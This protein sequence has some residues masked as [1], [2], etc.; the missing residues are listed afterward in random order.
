MEPLLC[1]KL[2]AGHWQSQ[3]K[4]GFLGHLDAGRVERFM[5]SFSGLCGAILTVSSEGMKPSVL[6]YTCV[7]IHVIGGREVTVS[8]KKALRTYFEHSTGEQIFLGAG[9]T[10]ARG[11]VAKLF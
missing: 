9:F 6:T 4:G 5:R 10:V 8:V 1:A 7:G 11:Q 2:S 3:V